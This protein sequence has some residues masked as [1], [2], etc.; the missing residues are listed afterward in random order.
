MKR[1]TLGLLPTQIDKGLLAPAEPER[2]REKVRLRRPRLALFADVPPVTALPWFAAP[3][4]VD[5]KVSDKFTDV[6]VVL[7]AGECI[8]RETAWRDTS[9]QKRMVMN[10]PKDSR[11]RIKAGSHTPTSVQD[12]P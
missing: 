12:R 6:L 7:T 2:L 8:G 1:G 11:N 9:N 5:L 10:L 3:S 4:A